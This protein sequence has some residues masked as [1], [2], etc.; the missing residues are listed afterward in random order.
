MLFRS[1][2]DN[3]YVVGLTKREDANTDDFAK[4]RSGLLEQMLSK[5]R[6]AVF[7]DYLMATKQKMEAGGYIKIYKE[8]LDKIDAPVPGAVPAGLPAGFPGQ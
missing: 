4:Q 7:S 1:V 5:K 2:G 8:A 6:N 3:W